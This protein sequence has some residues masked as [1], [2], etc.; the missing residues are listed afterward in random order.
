MPVFAPGLGYIAS[1]FL[2]SD[3]Q[4]SSV[5]WERKVAL[6]KDVWHLILAPLPWKIMN[7]NQYLYYCL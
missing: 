1:P 5:L 2:G 7:I 3:H 6:G 4:G